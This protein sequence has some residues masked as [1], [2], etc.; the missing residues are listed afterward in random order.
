MTVATGEPYSTGGKAYRA[1]RHVAPSSAI[2]IRRST[3]ASGA[4]KHDLSS[5]ERHVQCETLPKR[6]IEA[7]NSKTID[8]GSAVENNAEEFYIGEEVASSQ[9]ESVQNSTVAALQKSNA[10]EE[11]AVEE[12][13]Y[14][15]DMGMQTEN[16]VVELKVDAAC[17][18]TEREIFR[19][20]ERAR[21]DW[22]FREECQKKVDAH[23][24]RYPG[25]TLPADIR[26]VEE[27]VVRRKNQLKIIGQKVPRCQFC[28]HE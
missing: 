21:A 17:E 5:I 20:T 27:Y 10:S 9:V 1:A 6:M 16:G 23:K 24:A 15:V 12:G 25:G 2:A 26:D 22:S 4:A 3:R 13:N 14:F 18:A 11:Q 28:G 19:E 8:G 7:E